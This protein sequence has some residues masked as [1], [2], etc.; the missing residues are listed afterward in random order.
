[1]IIVSNILMFLHQKE[2]HV[3]RKYVLS[4]IV[5]PFLHY[6]LSFKW[7]TVDPYPFAFY[8]FALLYK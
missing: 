6:L 4:K 7:E 1:M 2:S 5:Y 8:D 3:R